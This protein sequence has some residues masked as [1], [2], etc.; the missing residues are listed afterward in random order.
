M[1]VFVL[2]VPALLVVVLGYVVGY[3][4]WEAT[5]LGGNPEIAGWLTGLVL[6]TGVTWALLSRPRRVRR[7]LRRARA[8]GLEAEVARLEAE[9]ARRRRRRG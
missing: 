4:V 2:A 3:L 9:V 5:G 8:R 1:S 6:L 7:A